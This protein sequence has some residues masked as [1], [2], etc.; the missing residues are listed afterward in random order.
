MPGIV[1]LSGIFISTPGVRTPI[2]SV[3]APAATAGTRIGP[4]AATPT[5]GATPHRGSGLDQSSDVPQERM[6]TAE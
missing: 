3:T 6:T 2:P 5:A 4:A 1:P